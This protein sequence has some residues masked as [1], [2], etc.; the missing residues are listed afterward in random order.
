M[1]DAFR[2]ELVAALKPLRGFA[3]TFHRNADRADDLVQETMM[4]AWANRDKFKPGTNMRAWLFTILRN[5]YYSELRKKRNEVEDVDGA[6][7]ARLAEKPAHDGRLAMNDFRSALDSLGDDQREALIL[8]GATGFS[9]EEAAEICGVAP[10]TVKSRVSRARQRL[11]EILGHNENEP[12]IEQDQK[13]AAS[14]GA[15]LARTSQSF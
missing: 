13:V 15:A 4:K 9:Y 2:D 3:R 1:S 8:V 12:V 10:G 7:T 11:A 14:G 6:H 5:S